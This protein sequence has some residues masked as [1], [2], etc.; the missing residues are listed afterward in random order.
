MTKTANPERHDLPLLIKQLADAIGEEAALKLFMRF[1]GRHLTIPLSIPPGHVIAETI[2]EDMAA[3]L[4]KNFHG[5][6]LMFPKGDYLHR[7]R[8]DEQIMADWK[9]GM[10]QCDLAT[11][12][13]LTERR[14]STIIN[15][16][17]G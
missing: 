17:Q 5:E 1:K 4:C 14:I 6:N 8:R 7:K 12:Y 2:G 9:S 16:A 15:N 11:K 13:Q 3:L 10:K